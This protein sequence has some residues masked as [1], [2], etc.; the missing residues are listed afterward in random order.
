MRI[1]MRRR[2]LGLLAA[3]GL[4]GATSMLSKGTDLQKVRVGVSMRN[5]MVHL[6]L[7]LAEQLGYFRQ[8]GII[9]DWHDFEAG[10]FANQALLNGHVDVISGQFEQVLDSNDRGH[11]LQAF[12]VQ[13]RTPQISLGIAMRQLASYQTIS[14]LK[15]FKIGIS[16]FHT[17]SHAMAN[18]WSLQAGLNPMEMQYIQVGGMMTAMDALRNGTVDV[19]CHVD[20]LMS[21]LEYKKDLRVVADTRSVQSAHLWLGGALA[22]TCLYAK[23]DFLSLKPE[24][25]QGLTDGVVRA[26]RWL[27]TAGPTDV[28]RAVPPNV[29]MGDRAFYLGTLDKVRDSY[30]PDGLFTEELLQTAW[31]SRALRLGWP[32]INAVDRRALLLA[33]TNAAVQKIKKRSIV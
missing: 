30:S 6:P 19:L 21:W 7:V 26:L 22:S 24:L 25:M 2:Q 15:R 9:V 8:A 17:S 12:V 3:A 33:Y 31:R 27:L 23:T 10:S 28:L 16:G 32:R 18:M 14:D 4:L 29:W 13:G 5:S 11:K 1:V 20:P